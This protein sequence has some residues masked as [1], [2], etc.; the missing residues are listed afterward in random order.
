MRSI[1]V[2]GIGPNNVPGPLVAALLNFTQI[3]LL[4]VVE[5]EALVIV[6]GERL[7]QGNLDRSKVDTIVLIQSA[8]SCSI[9]GMNYELFQRTLPPVWRHTRCSL[10][11]T[12]S[13]ASRKLRKSGI[14]FSFKTLKSSS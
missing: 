5:V 8:G 3:I 4:R 12:A 1:A 9:D 14:F 6:A 7:F 13:I 2:N 10:G 11:H